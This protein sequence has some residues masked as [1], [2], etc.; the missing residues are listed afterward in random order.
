MKEVLQK[1]RKFM[2]FGCGLAVA[3]AAMANTVYVSAGSPEGQARLI[4]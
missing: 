1:V 3:G 2:A 4:D